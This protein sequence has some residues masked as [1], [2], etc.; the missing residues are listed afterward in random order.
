MSYLDGN[1]DLWDYQKCPICLGYTLTENVSLNEFL[2]ASYLSVKSDC[3]HG[4]ENFMHVSCECSFYANIRD[5]DAFGI[6]RTDGGYDFVGVLSSD[7]GTGWL[8]EF[9]VEVF[10]RDRF[11]R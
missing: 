4:S 6:T 9:A 7:A 8:M 11:R 2:N 1:L 3:F 10:K 5:F